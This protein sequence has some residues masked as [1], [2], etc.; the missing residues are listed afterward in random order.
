[1]NKKCSG[2][3]YKNSFRETQKYPEKIY[4]ISDK[5]TVFNSLPVN[6]G[7]YSHPYWLNDLH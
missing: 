5:D 7:I 1:V 6:V 2:K 3:K 4:K